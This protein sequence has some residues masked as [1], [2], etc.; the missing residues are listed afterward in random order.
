MAMA[1]IR[2]KASTPSAAP[3]RRCSGSQLARGGGVAPGGAGQ[4]A[5]ACA[6]SARQIAAIARP[7][8]DE[9]RGRR[10]SDRAVGGARART[11]RAA[12]ARGGRSRSGTTCHR[13]TL[14]LHSTVTAEDGA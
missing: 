9:R 4:A 1:V 6:A 3:S 12:C 13:P 8:A 5:D 2:P 14:T 10:A 7:S 11:A